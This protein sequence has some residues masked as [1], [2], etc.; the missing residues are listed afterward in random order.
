[1]FK[2]FRVLILLTI[3]LV[4]GVREWR[5]QTRVVSWNE[6]LRIAVFPINVEGTP[7]VAN[8]IGALREGSFSAVADFF[9]EEMQRYGM[10]HPEPVKIILGPVMRSQ[11]PALPEDASRLDIM[12]WSLKLRWWAWQET[13]SVGYDPDVRLYLF[14]H[15]PDLTDNAPHSRGMQ[16]GRIGLVHAFSGRSMH[17]VT[18]FVLTHELLHTLGATDK[19]D[20]ATGEPRWPDGY[21]EPDLN[22]RYPQ[23]FAEIMGGKVPQS[24]Q[25]S[26]L[27]RSLRQGLVGPETAAEI[28]WTRH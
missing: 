4:V 15:D 1:M 3:L 6:P 9:T 25:Y 18:Q 17:G 24:P 13:P 10:S 5:N 26:L 28:G 16:K 21:A 22:P 2:R 27:P 19:Y 20:L 14:Y 7:A 8:Y 11:P 23:S 12:L